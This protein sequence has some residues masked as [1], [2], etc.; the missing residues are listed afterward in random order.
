MKVIWFL[1]HSF[2]IWVFA[3]LEGRDYISGGPG[4]RSRNADVAGGGGEGGDVWQVLP[5]WVQHGLK[6]IQ[7]ALGHKTC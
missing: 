1:L 3:A 4:V 5:W 7:C 2:S 6:S